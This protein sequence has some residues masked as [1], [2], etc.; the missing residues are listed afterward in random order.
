VVSEPGNY[1]ALALALVPVGSRPESDG[2]RLHIGPQA[3]SLE[4]SS[5]DRSA[6]A[7]LL[8]WLKPAGGPIGGG[9]IW[10]ADAGHTPGHSRH[11][12]SSLA[13]L[14]S[15]RDTRIREPI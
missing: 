10:R 14:R 15:D 9:T 13:Q 7:E 5:V 2:L 1:R 4:S 12:H 3:I 6:R 8:G 11:A